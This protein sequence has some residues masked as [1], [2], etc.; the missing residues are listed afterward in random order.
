MTRLGSLSNRIFLASALL[1]VVSIA[2]AVW[3]IDRTLTSQAGREVLRGLAEA[4][5]LVE[6]Y[7][8]LSLTQLS[9]SARLIA[10]LP[11]FKAAVELNDPPTVAPLA[12]DYRR[13]LGAHLFVVVGRDG[14]LLAQDGE[15]GL[16]GLTLVEGAGLA[17]ALEGH[18]GASFVPRDAGILQLVTVPIWIDPD[19][20]D[21]LG[22]LGVGVAL[23]TAFA[24]QIKRLTESDIAFAWGGEVKATS[25]ERGLATALEPLL[26]SGRSGRVR[27]NDEEYDASVRPLADSAAVGA[28]SPA[29][30]DAV[31]TEGAVVVL[32]SRTERLRPMR[33]LQAALGVTAAIA[34]LL[35]IMLSYLVAR[36]IT[37]PIGTLTAAM[38]DVAV[39]GDLSRAPVPAPSRWED[40]DARILTR[41]FGAMTASIARF[42]QEAAQRERLS[43]L[44]RLSTVL[45]HEIRNPLMIIKASLRALR[46]LEPADSAATAA[47]AD[48]DGEVQRLNA[49]VDD[50]LDYARP[51][52]FRIGPADLSAICAEAVSASE[53]DGE[54]PTCFLVLDEAAN[55]LV[56]DEERLRQA[57]VNVLGNARQ[58]VQSRDPSLSGTNDAPTGTPLLTLQTRARRPDRVEIS[59]RDRGAGMDASTLAR[60]FDP[61]FTTKSTGTGIG[62]AI[63][64]NIVEGLGG[65]I[66]VDSEAGRGTEVTMSLPRVAS[67]PSEQPS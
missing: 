58:A 49:L 64:R 30:V 52:R 43:A 9:Q 7:R 40:E 23:D 56:T 55:A 13:Q 14:R 59:V 16:T 5:T 61:Y 26:R 39:S 10:D 41:A 54:G 6:E 15:E 46:R 11:K 17:R 67:P 48:I 29:G 51:I 36:T 32:R 25:L 62:L 53:A 12:A 1:A 24:A 60:A 47:L 31:P 33:S 65:T 18:H 50:V 42:Q 2:V 22:A 19:A 66:R 38:R 35:A 8:R 45:A 20:P 57:L 63:A 34:V 3:L 4:D 27:L 44:G 28:V 37:R 21:V